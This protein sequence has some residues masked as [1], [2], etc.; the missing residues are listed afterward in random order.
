M[1]QF[2]G[3]GIGICSVDENAEENDVAWFYEGERPL[4]EGEHF[5]KRFT[6]FQN[7]RICCYF[8]R[9]FIVIKKFIN[10]RKKYQ[11]YYNSMYYIVTIEDIKG[12]IV[13]YKNNF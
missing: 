1:I 12:I 13:I 8:L 10:K 9:I 7:Y 11:E 4:M 2:K 5:V 6:L 3:K